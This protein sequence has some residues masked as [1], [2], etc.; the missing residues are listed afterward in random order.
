[1]GVDMLC[2][3]FLAF[4]FAPRVRMIIPQTTSSF[5]GPTMWRLSFLLIGQT[6]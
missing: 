3:R 5:S 6:A 4:F 2:C 1:M